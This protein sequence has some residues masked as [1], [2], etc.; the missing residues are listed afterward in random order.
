MVR[1]SHPKL[2]KRISAPSPATLCFAE[3]PGKAVG[4]THF[5][6]GIQHSF[7]LLYFTLGRHKSAIDS[8]QSTISNEPNE[9]LADS[10]FWNVKIEG[11]IRQLTEE[12]SPASPDFPGCR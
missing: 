1:K 7:Y 6:V 12:V 3:G 10:W 4:S 2:R 8:Q 11:S 5:T 9:V